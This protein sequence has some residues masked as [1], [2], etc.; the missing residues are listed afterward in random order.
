MEEFKKL[1]EICQ[2]DSRQ[3]FFVRSDPSSPDEFRA[4]TIQ[5]IYKAVESIRLHEGV[6]EKVRSHFETAWNLALYAWFFYPFNVTAHLSA[7]TSIEYALRT[8]SDDRKTAFKQLLRNAVDNGWIKDHGFSIPSQR[9]ERIRERNAEMPAEFQE[10][11]PSLMR[12]YC[13]VLCES[14]P[15]LRNQLAHGSSML[16]GD[17]IG[18]IRIA[19]ELINQLFIG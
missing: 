10:P 18:P 19:A 3:A 17:G 6:P 14:I 16:H 4:T 2:P 5:D 1:D 11:E 13:D 7:Y 8:K 15:F 12:D 9:V